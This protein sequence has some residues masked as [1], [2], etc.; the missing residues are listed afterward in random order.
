MINETGD[1][2]SVWVDFHLKL[3]IESSVN[4]I[5]W[6]LRVVCKN[7]CPFPTG[8]P[9][10][11][12]SVAQWIQDRT[13]YSQGILAIDHA[14]LIISN[15]TQ[16]IY[17]NYNIT[18]DLDHSYNNFQMS[19]SCILLPRGQKDHSKKLLHQ[20]IGGPKPHGCGSLR[21]PSKLDGL[22]SKKTTICRSCL[23]ESHGETR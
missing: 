17:Y 12:I 13:I 5:D 23:L 19:N 21:Q 10:C 15:Y 4:L 16:M 11:C 2:C 1:S 20:K 22:P 14:W 18:Q 3:N 7:S 8:T 9:P 6:N